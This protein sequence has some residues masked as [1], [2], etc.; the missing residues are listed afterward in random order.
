MIYPVQPSSQGSGGRNAPR[1]IFTFILASSLAGIGCKDSESNFAASL[2]S[3][4][5]PVVVAPKDSTDG[6][7]DGDR[8]EQGVSLNGC[9]TSGDLPLDGLLGVAVPSSP[10]ADSSA[11]ILALDVSGEVVANQALYQRI[12]AELTGLRSAFPS[13]TNVDAAP[14]F[15]SSIVATL[16]DSRASTTLF[17]AYNTLLRAQLALLGDGKTLIIKFDGIFNA[18]TLAEQ[19][20]ALPN[21]DFAAPDVTRGDNSDICLEEL[22]NNSHLYIFDHGTG[23]CPAGCEQHSFSSFTVDA[24]GN[25]NDLGDFQPQNDIEVPAWFTDAASCRSYL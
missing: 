6:E 4:T 19:Y 9:E 13:R 18:K 16:G 12:N 11:E 17:D 2:G 15:P 25:I 23:D 7:Q 14:C 10:R 1:M 21:I 5:P 20:D 24:D 22:P 8:S 3:N